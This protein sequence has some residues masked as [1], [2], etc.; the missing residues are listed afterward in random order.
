MPRT[1][2]FL[3]L[4]ILLFAAAAQA[5]LVINPTTTYTAETSKNTSASS[6]FTD[7]YFITKQNAT[8]TNGD[9]VPR[10]V[11]KVDIHELYPNNNTKIYAEWQAWWCHQTSNE[12]ADGTL[13]PNTSQHSC[14]S[15]IDIG[16]SN[17]QS[18]VT[19]EVSDMMSRGFAGAIIDWN[20]PGTISDTSAGYL[21]TA[22]E[23]T[24]G[25]FQFAIMIDKG[26]FGSC[27]ASGTCTSTGITRVQDVMNR[28][29]SSSAYMKT[30]DS[31]PMI[32]FFVDG[33]TSPNNTQI[34]W[35]SLRSNSGGN[36]LFLGDGKGNFSVMDG[37]YGW[38]NV[39]LTG[40]RTGVTY[41]D[42]FYQSATSSA[43]ASKPVVGAA[44]KGF[45][46]KLASWSP[47]P[48]N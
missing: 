19:A 27:V 15:H 2:R 14:S 17:T 36:P 29:A 18:Q 5:Q 4:V 22:A 37:A 48:P 12:Q 40:D 8:V 34:D 13:N 32:F 38:E 7:V 47:A 3:F 46:D 35:A 9:A 20:G 16:Y 45:N 1:S 21:R 23:A 6:M 10:N 30:S 39:V 28:Y 33:G 44:F 25:Q 41:L 43:N 26:A 24:G 11:S 31:R 42:Q